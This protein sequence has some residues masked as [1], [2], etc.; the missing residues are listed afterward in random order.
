MDTILVSFC[1]LGQFICVDFEH[2]LRTNNP[3]KENDLAY[4]LIDIKQKGARTKFLIFDNIISSI[5][6]PI[7][8]NLY[9]NFIIIKFY[10]YSTP[11]N[12]LWGHF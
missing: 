10:S 11:E 5:S 12:L 7:C 1:Y 4:K 9:P 6:V 8:K 3:K 2:F